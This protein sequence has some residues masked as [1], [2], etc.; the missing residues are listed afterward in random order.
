MK[1][2]YFIIL[3]VLVAILSGCSHEKEQVK[4]KLVDAVDQIQGMETYAPSRALSKS[5]GEKVFYEVSKVT[6]NGDIGVAEV[7]V[8]TPDLERIIADAIQ[9]AI[10]ANGI[11]DYDALLESVKANIKAVLDSEDY[12][13]LKSA[14]EMSA[15][16]AEDGYTLIS[17]EEF[18]KI[19]SGNPEKIFM[20][21]LMEG[22]TNENHN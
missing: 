15:E 9:K 2:I 16:K 12:P 7:E 3:V 14:V 10:D 5:F 22:L 20:Q 21:A 6:W 8:T 17:N 11:E 19:V 1:R 13:T 4:V 18:E